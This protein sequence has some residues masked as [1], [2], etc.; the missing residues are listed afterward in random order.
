[1]PSRGVYLSKKG[2]KSY[3]DTWKKNKVLV[4][5]D[6]TYKIFEAIFYR[7]LDRTYYF[8]A[9]LHSLLLI[10]LKAYHR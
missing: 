7:Y 8:A 10:Q 4:S 2:P 1:M 3:R 6:N 5:F 9:A